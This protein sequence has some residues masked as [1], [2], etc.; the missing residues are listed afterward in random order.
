MNLCSLFRQPGIT[1]DKATIYRDLSLRARLAVALR[2]FERYCQTKGLRHPLVDEFLDRMWEL[3]CIES[4]PDWESRPCALVHVGLGDT[5]P[6]EFADLFGRDKF[7]KREF[8][9]LLESSVEIIYCSAYGKGDNTASLRFLDR[10]LSISFAA[11]V[12]PPAVQPF[13]GSSFVD[14]DGWGKS[15]SPAQRDEW[16]FK[17][18]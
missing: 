15:L 4:L 13:A 2:C 6:P 10:V 8:K 11:N 16:R 14:H 17:A 9:E 5:F 1:A 18:C 12:T 7:L 3:P